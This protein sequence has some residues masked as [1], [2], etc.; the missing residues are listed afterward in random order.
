MILGIHYERESTAK[1]IAEKT[2]VRALIAIAAAKQLVV[3]H[4]DL[5]SAY[6]HEK[7]AP[8]R[9]V[10]IKQHP[11]FDGTYKYT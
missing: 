2:S 4:F 1:Y 7:Y 6:L 9:K 5:T 10:Y 11:M 3:E 8:E